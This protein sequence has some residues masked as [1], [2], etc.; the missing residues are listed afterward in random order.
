MTFVECCLSGERLFSCKLCHKNFTQSS[1][2]TRHERV[3]TGERPFTCDECEQTFSQ[4][5]NLRVH[6]RVH[7][8]ER[9]YCCGGCNKTFKQLSNM[10]AHMRIH[11][12]ERPFSCTICDKKF[13]KSSN[14]TRHHARVHS[15]TVTWTDDVMTNWSFLCCDAI[16]LCIIMMIL[17]HLA[18]KYA[19]KSVT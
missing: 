14:L 13:T 3:H 19:T 11:T 17:R 2:L 1:D 15:H 16:S 18:Q 7:T 9:P 12:G 6:M 5:N 8:D 10:H 4:L